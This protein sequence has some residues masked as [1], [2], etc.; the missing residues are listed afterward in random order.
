MISQTET[1]GAGN[2]YGFYAVP[3]ALEPKKKYRDSADEDYEDEPEQ[4]DFN[5]FATIEDRRAANERELDRDYYVDEAPYPEFKPRE[6]GLDFG[7]QIERGDLFDFD[8]EVKPLI[9]ILVGR[10]VVSAMNELQEEKERDERKNNLDKYQK[11]R[12][13]ELMV[14]Q[15]LEAKHKRKLE[16]AERRRLQKEL[17]VKNQK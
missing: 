13:A 5:V 7:V 6:R 15:R 3:K 12:N 17:Y 10:S 9:E 8:L 2:Q 4:E 16:E 1:A 14:T 11:K